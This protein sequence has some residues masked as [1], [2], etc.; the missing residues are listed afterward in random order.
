MC[1]GL[2]A[3][4][5]A[6]TAHKRIVILISM[7]DASY[8]N[9]VVWFLYF[10]VA[11]AIGWVIESTFR[12]VTEHHLVNSGFL[13]GPF[14]PIYGFGSLALAALARALA[15]THWVLFWPLLVVTPA[16]V[17]YGSSYLLEKIFGLRLWDYS[18]EP[19]NLRGRICLRFSVYWAV[20][21]VLTIRFI[22]PFLLAHIRSLGEYTRVYLAGA[23]SMYF[24]MDTVGSSKALI[25]FKAFIVDL[26]ALVERGGSFLPSL[27]LD[28]K[29]LPR[30]IRHIVKPLKSFPTLVA[31][32]RPSL[33][34]IPGWIT[35]K[36]ES[37]IGGRHFSK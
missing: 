20:L 4:Y 11:A 19:L 18:K 33:D 37:I 10:S 12:T 1:S 27:E 9:L 23:L 25:N 36:L 5:R 17:E 35:S 15:H 2:P 7:L 28:T 29:R 22:E 16:I 34:A 3:G 32:L 13:T 6:L 14:I 26:R 21:T 8:E 31:E 30:E 24:V